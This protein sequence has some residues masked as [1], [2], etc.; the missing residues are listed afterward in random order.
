MEPNFICRSCGK[1]ISVSNSFC[2][3]CGAPQPSIKT[4]REFPEEEELVNEERITAELETLQDSPLAGRIRTLLCQLETVLELSPKTLEIV[5]RFKNHKDDGVRAMVHTLKRKSDPD[6]EISSK[7]KT[8]M[9]IKG[10][11]AAKA[12]EYANRAIIF[13]IVGLCLFGFFFGPVAIYNSVKALK[14]DRS[15]T[16]APLG[17]LMGV[18]DTIIWTL[19]F[20]I[21]FWFIIFFLLD[22]LSRGI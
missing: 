2:G 22:N 11:H 15:N 5:D 6:Y 20:I 10:A 21:I 14:S 18:T 12:N 13:G 3:Y 1:K 19:P 16:K 7:I 4:Q 17:I 9:A 8:M